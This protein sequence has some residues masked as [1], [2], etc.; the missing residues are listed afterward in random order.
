MFNFMT[1]NH[2]IIVECRWRSVGAVSSAVS[3]WWI[4]GGGDSWGKDPEK[5]VLLHL[6]GKYRKIEETLQ[7]NL[8]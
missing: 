1:N 8:F 3:S 7:A 4:L 2:K 6:E 5:L